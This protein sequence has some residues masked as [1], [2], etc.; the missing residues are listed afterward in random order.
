MAMFTVLAGVVG[1]GEDPGFNSQEHTNKALTT[2]PFD[3]TCKADEVLPEVE[4]GVFTRL[5]CLQ[6]QL[7]HRYVIISFTRHLA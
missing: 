1:T 3:N 4:A 7:G 5:R 2:N 6:P